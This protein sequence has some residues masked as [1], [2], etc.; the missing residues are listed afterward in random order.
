MFYYKNIANNKANKELQTKQ[1]K[2]KSHNTQSNFKY[3]QMICNKN[4][5]QKT[6]NKTEKKSPNIQFK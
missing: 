3:I 5:K 6:K 1:K 4:K 2:R